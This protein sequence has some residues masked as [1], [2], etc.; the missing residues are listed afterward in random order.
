MD[1][2]IDTVIDKVTMVKIGLRSGPGEPDDYPLMSGLA[3]MVLTRQ[4]RLAVVDRVSGCEMGALKISFHAGVM[5]F[6]MY[7]YTDAPEEAYAARSTLINANT[8]RIPHEF[9]W[10]II[11]RLDA[12]IEDLEQL[13]GKL[14]AQERKKKKK[15]N[16][17]N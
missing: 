13:R 2:E 8:Q 12:W 5:E 16:W 6:F 7:L 15:K 1:I 3:K 11:S 10:P 17:R 9:M 4:I 14:A